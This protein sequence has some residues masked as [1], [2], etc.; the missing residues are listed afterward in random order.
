MSDTP[1]PAPS[2][3]T[4]AGDLA[5]VTLMREFGDFEEEYGSVHGFQHPAEPGGLPAGW[6]LMA[7]GETLRFANPVGSFTNE[8]C[9]VHRRAGGWG[10]VLHQVCSDR[11]ACTV[12]L[13]MAEAS[14][15]LLYEELRSLC[16]HPAL[17]EAAGLDTIRSYILTRYDLTDP[18]EAAEATLVGLGAPVSMFPR[19]LTE[20]TEQAAD[21]SM[22]AD[23]LAR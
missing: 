7:R 4:E 13:G 10:L 18:D 9:L 12:M 21:L 16:A 17:V 11:P 3:A 1:S 6:V 5:Y 20:N 14:V 15:P 19:S 22:R 8:V 23:V 2:P